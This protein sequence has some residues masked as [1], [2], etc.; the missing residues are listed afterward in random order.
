VAAVEGNPEVLLDD[1]CRNGWEGLIAKRRD[2]LYQSGRSPDWRKLKCSATQDLV[3]G[4]WTDPAGS[5][6]GLGA[7]LVGYFDEQDQLRYAGKVGTGFDDKQLTELRR[8]LADLA[9]SDSPFA[10]VVKVKGSHWVRPEMVVA[11]AFS[12]WTNDG[13][14]R[15]P[16]F[17]GVRPDKS[18]VAVRRELLP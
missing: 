11:V 16:R 18:P 6:V 4:G 9:A 12:E 1:A 2:S 5:R 14:L 3:V 7:L 17:E 10:D 13:R 8:A 15:H